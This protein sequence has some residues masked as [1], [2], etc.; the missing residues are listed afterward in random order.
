[1]KRL[2]TVLMVCFLFLVAGCA[3]SGKQIMEKEGCFSCHRYKGYGA[4]ICPDLTEITKRRSDD[5]I[6]QQLK[7]PSKNFTNSK[8]PSFNYLSD[9]DIDAIIKFLKTGQ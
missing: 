8:M 7:D 9:R 1:M 6:R 3:K 2:L 5:F 4:D